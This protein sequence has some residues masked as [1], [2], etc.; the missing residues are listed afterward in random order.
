MNPTLPIDLPEWRALR[1]HREDMLATRLRDLFAADPERGPKM[2]FEAAGLYFDFSKNYADAATVRLLHG[3]ARAAGL[4]ERIDAMF[5]GDR[6]NST[7]DRSVLHVAL[8]APRDASIVVD[9]VDVVPGVHEVLDRCADFA[10]R[11]R[12][13]DWTGHTGARIRHV[14]N[15]GIGGSDLG[16]A[17][18]VEALQ[19][20]ADRDM[21]VR[22]VSNVDGTHLAEAVRDLD[23]AATLFVVCSKTFTT[24]E[25]LANA[26]SAREWLCAALGEEAVAK[27]FVAVSTN[28]EAVAAFGID[29][30]NM[31]GFWDWVGGRYSV[32]SAVGLSLM[33]A[34]G[35]SMF[36]EFLAGF[37]AMDEHFF[38]APFPRNAPV[39]MGM[40]RVWYGSF[41][42][43]ASH[44]VLPYDQ[45]LARF[46]AYLQQ[47]DMESNGKR[48]TRDG[49][50]V[51]WHTGSVVWGEPGTNGQ[52]AF[53]QLLHQGTRIV[54]CD[55]IGFCRSLNPGGDHHDQLMANLFAQAEALAFGKS[56]DEVRAEG[57]PEELVPHK[58]FPGNRPSTLILAEELT[59]RTLGSLIALYE[60]AVFVAG[61]VWNIH[62]FD[63]W[64]VE[65]GKQLARRI[66]PELSAETDP[67]LAHDSSTNA[68]IHRYRA[69]R[70]GGN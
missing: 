4:R 15:L 5:A 41:L 13:G 61:S 19:H 7:E 6:I 67:V 60:H 27:H 64:G 46:P 1:S 34:I 31:F 3:L 32:G 39:V 49:A 30:A 9:G 29:T 12:S 38:T 65:L 58:T 57:A 10:D 2:S 37:R 53:F 48:V 25:T 8:R 66:A 18:C 21:D 40:L 54:P 50:D 24:L 11:V 23:P 22:F 69:L 70:R 63:Q 59:P 47:L 20:Y 35:P 42:D 17:M 28:A 55:F 45:Y 14:V 52:H 36:R 43:C 56:A 33:L 62:S 16:P 51:E 68:L 44:A 26:R